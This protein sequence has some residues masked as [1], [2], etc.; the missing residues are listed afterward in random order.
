MEKVL[1]T[2]LKGRQDEMVGWM[3]HW[4]IKILSFILFWSQIGLDRPRFHSCNT[5]GDFANSPCTLLSLLLYCT[6]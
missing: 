3:E 6:V 1:L 5:Y 2:G 4:R